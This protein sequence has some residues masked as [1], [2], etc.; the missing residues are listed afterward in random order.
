MGN[1]YNK[2]FV[3]D[4]EDLINKHSL[5]NGSDTPDYILADY[6]YNCLLNYNDVVTRKVDWHKG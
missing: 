1:E 5:E 2:E 6:M 3:K 4:L